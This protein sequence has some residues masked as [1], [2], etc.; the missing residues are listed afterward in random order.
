LWFF[1][2]GIVVSYLFKK[3]IVVS[4]KLEYTES[5]LTLSL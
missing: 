3:H 2:E 5:E 4:I 1:G